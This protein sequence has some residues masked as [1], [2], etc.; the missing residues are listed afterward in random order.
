[1]K[2]S[3]LRGCYNGISTGSVQAESADSPV[4]S[5]SIIDPVGGPHTS[6]GRVPCQEL[7]IKAVSKK[8]MGRYEACASGTED[9][10]SYRH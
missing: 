8:G 1:M 9:S 4:E 2:N 3:I 10:D 6:R 7:D 5:D